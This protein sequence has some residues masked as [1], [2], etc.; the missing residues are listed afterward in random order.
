MKHASLPHFHVGTPGTDLCPTAKV[1]TLNLISL[2]SKHKSMCACMH[3][4]THT[5]K[6]THTDTNTPLSGGEIGILA[7][8][9]HMSPSRKRSRVKILSC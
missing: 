6:C 1:G 2:H 7:H 5:H 9:V 8:R 3:S 4:P